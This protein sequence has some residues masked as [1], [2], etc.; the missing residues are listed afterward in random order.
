MNL[1]KY[2]PMIP[3]THAPFSSGSWIYEFKL[4]GY[5]LIAGR[6]SRAVGLRLRSGDSADQWFPEICEELRSIKRN[7]VIDGEVCAFDQT[8]M[9]YFHALARRRRG[10]A[11]AQLEFPVVLFAFDLLVFDSKDLRT[12][13]IE[14]RKACLADLLEGRNAAIRYVPHIQGQGL[15]LFLGAIEQGMEGVVAKRMGSPYRSG[16][17]LDWL[18]FLNSSYRRRKLR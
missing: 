11:R 15:D 8:G 9:P 3:R 2:D 4:D 18:K 10:S 5:R 12:E 17:T 16:R 7:F 6:D 1:S 13:P 14:K